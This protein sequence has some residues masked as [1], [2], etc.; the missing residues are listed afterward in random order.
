MELAQNNEVRNITDKNTLSL[1]KD[2]QPGC[3]KRIGVVNDG[4]SLL[5]A[6]ALAY[7]KPYQEGQLIDNLGN[8]YAVE[9][10]QFVADL[11]KELSYLNDSFGKDNVNSS[12]Q[13]KILNSNFHLDSRFHPIISVVLGIRLF[14]ISGDQVT[15]YPRTADDT[16]DKTH[17][18]VIS[19]PNNYELF[20]FKE[21]TRLITSFAHDHPILKSLF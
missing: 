15:V 6:I 13:K 21:G 5:H 17:I 12:E 8:V 20:A 3:I 9:K 10:R 16:K 18:V 2:F 7:F 11:R 19:Y 1:F 4:S 14:V